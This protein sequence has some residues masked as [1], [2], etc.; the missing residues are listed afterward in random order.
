V[1]PCAADASVRASV[2]LVVVTTF[3]DAAAD[4]P[5]PH[6]KYQLAAVSSDVILASPL[7]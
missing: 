1:V 2:V 3:A 5:V 6:C 4:E 7:F